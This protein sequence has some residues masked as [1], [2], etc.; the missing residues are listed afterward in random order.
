MQHSPLS[1]FMEPHTRSLSH[2]LPPSPP[3]WPPARNDLCTVHDAS[4]TSTHVYRARTR[5]LSTRVNH[6]RGGG[7]RTWTMGAREEGR[8]VDRG[9]KSDNEDMPAQDRSARMYAYSREGPPAR[10]PCGTCECSGALWM[11]GRYCNLRV[12]YTESRNN[13]SPFF[14]A[15]EKHA[16]LCRIRACSAKRLTVVHKI[17]ITRL[18]ITVWNHNRNN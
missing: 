5:S 9:E 1:T 18:L 3:R 11:T 15:R 7:W 17:I 16:L 2:R 4:S 12:G 10:R 6:E 8:P 14:Q 13:F